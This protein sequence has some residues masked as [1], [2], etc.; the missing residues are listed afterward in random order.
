[1]KSTKQV[2]TLHTPLHL[3]VKIDLGLIGFPI[4]ISKAAPE[5]SFFILI[6]KKSK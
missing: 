1:M 6:F 2:A 5:K 3:Y 4:Q